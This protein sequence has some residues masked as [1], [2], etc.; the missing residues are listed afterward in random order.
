MDTVLLVS[1]LLEDVEDDVGCVPAGLISVRWVSS[2]EVTRFST[3]K[4]GFIASSVEVSG[5]SPFCDEL[6]DEGLVSSSSGV[7][8]IYLD[9]VS[10][11]AT[12]GGGAGE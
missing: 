2:C 12:E 8:V 5:S 11:F 1:S 3:T 4:G 6:V 10:F 9:A 7:T